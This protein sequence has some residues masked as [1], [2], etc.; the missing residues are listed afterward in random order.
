MGN[1]VK[2]IKVRKVFSLGGRK[3]SVSDFGGFNDKSVK[4]FKKAIAILSSKQV[5]PQP[6][7]YINEWYWK[8]Y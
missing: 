7:Y 4:D 2:P 3:I 5:F 1:K 8:K 6:N